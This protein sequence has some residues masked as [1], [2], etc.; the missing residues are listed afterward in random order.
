MI[1]FQSPTFNS[2]G[3]NVKLEASV[4][5]GHSPFWRLLKEAEERGPGKTVPLS[6]C[7]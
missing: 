4:A 1:L 5:S 2:P 3:S 7:M 6:I